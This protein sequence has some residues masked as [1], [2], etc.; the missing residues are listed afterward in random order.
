MTTAPATALPVPH[1]THRPG[2]AVTDP[3]PARQA[4][5]RLRL[6]RYEPDPTA[7]PPASSARR[8]RTAA[9][10]PED[11]WPGGAKELAALRERAGQV[12]RLVL[13]VLDG[14]R[15][16][17][18]LSAHLAPPA[19]RYVRAAHA[20]RPAVRQ[21]SRMT[22]LHVS[23]PCEDA[24]EVTAVYRLR[25]RARALAARFEGPAPEDPSSWRCVTLRLL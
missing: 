6:L 3:A 15:P 7:P 16:L 17:T 19:L 12:L 4:A 14:R 11:P 2:L 18:H 21:P 24:V 25:E 13:E 9:L 23:R 8:E 20:Q 5:P 10:A 22:S 1:G